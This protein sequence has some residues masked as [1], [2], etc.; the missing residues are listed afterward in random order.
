LFDDE[1][2]SYDNGKPVSDSLEDVKGAEILHDECA[3]KQED[4]TVSLAS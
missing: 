3:T 1:A 2:S 4:M